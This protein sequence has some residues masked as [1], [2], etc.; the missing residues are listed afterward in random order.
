ML[1]SPPKAACVSNFIYWLDVP[2]FK[3]GVSVE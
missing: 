3:T 2:F 1:L